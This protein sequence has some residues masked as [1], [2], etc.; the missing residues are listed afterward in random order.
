[1]V[2]SLDQG[3]K[4]ESQ[5]PP[6]TAR[7]LSPRSEQ[8]LSDRRTSIASLPLSG[9]PA[10][11]PRSPSLLAQYPRRQ[12]L[13]AETRSILLSGLPDGLPRLQTDSFSP[14][15][16]RR[17]SLP[18]SF[19]TGRRSS[20]QLRQKLQ[21]WGHV[22]FGNGSEA[23]CFVSAVA[24]RR[25]SGSSSADEGAATEGRPAEHRNRVTI[26]ARVRPC[27]LDR[28]PFLLRRT[29]DMDELRS[30]IPELSP[31]SP[32]VWSPST[33]LNGR[34]ALPSSPR[35]SSNASADHGMDLDRWPIRSTNTVPIHLRYA[36]A[37][38]PVLAVL[39]YSDHVHA[40]DIIDLPLPHPEAWVQT[41]ALAYTG[42]GELTEAIKQNILYLGGKV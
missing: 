9:A 12:T 36:R 10:S 13:V 6:T 15:A 32:G 11:S 41:V 1:M 25:P 4:L 18:P 14:L 24:L 42:Q 37:F 29:F 20:Q 26:R 16:D 34:S 35:R 40:R 21:A 17:R 38:F 22:Y 39:I 28:K 23:N 30:T 7:L 19:P 3:G 31:V 2:D 33:E 8:A 5:R 27:A